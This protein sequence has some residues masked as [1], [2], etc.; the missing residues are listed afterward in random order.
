[1]TDNSGGNIAPAYSLAKHLISKPLNGGVFLTQKWFA[2][3]SKLPDSNDYSQFKE[4]S[5]GN[6]NLII[7]GI[8]NEKGIVLKLMPDELIFKGKIYILINKNTASTCEPLVYGL[9]K[10][11]IATIVGQRS[12][13]AMLNGEIFD[14]AGQFQ[15]IIPTADYYTS[16]GVRLDGKGVSP[17]VEVAPEKALDYILSKLIKE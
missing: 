10:N 9:Q 17:D 16:D 1:L 12:A 3:N 4:L 7:S 11:G 2:L 5:E 8:H 15:L 13:G 6:Y 14:I